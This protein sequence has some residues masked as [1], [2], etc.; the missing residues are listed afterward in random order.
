MKQGRKRLKGREAAKNMKISSKMMA[1]ALLLVMAAGVG[2]IH[3]YLSVRPAASETIAGHSERTEGY[4]TVVDE[5]GK[6]IFT[7]GHMVSVGDEYID[8]FDTKYV[9]ISVSGDRATAREVGKAAALSISALLSVFETAAPKGAIGIYHTH[10]S[11]SYIPSDMT[12]SIPGKGGI[13]EVGTALANRLARSGVKVN[14]DTTS[15][16]PNDA[17]AYDRSRRTAVSL[18]KKQTPI[19]LFDVHRDAGPAEPYLEEID[20]TEVA[21]CMIVIGRQNPK[22][23]SNLEFARQLKDGVNNQYPG[24]VKGIFM[25]NADF[26]QDL[27]DRA[28]LLEIGT[29]KTSKEAA[30]RGAAYI[31][32]VIPN[33]LP[34]SSSGS[35]GLSAGKAIGW[36]LGV[37]VAGV[38]A[39]LWIATGSW[40]EMK[41]KLLGWFGSGGIRL[42]DV[43][44]IGGGSDTDTPGSGE[45]NDQ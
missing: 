24:L 9:I 20:G 10:S 39:Y 37:T 2:I 21:K 4:Y 8:E 40:E 17:R 29:E 31:G 42:G 34:S 16:D 22:M 41:A 19:A 45:G 13:V 6:T 35:Q 1:W 32:S 25:G 30:M 12:D 26:N 3:L 36:I 23:Q 15:H 43:D 5:T 38:F 44:G 11:E 18:L 27:F 7:T 14:H 28:L 33:L